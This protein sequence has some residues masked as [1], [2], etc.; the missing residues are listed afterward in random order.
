MS[1]VVEKPIIN[2]KGPTGRGGNSAVYVRESFSFFLFFFFSFF[3]ILFFL[4]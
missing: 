4:D 3:L 2:G 1:Y